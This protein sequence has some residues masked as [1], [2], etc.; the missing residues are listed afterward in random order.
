MPE[1]EQNAL[2]RAWKIQEDAAAVG[3]DWPDISGVLDKIEE[4]VNEMREAL[5]CGDLNHARQ[6]LGDVLLASVNAA[7]FLKINPE[8]MLTQAAN[9]FHARFQAVENVFAQEG[10]DMKSCSLDELDAVWNRVKVAV[11]QALENSA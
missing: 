4:E 10:R 6:E 1:Y 8:V 5:S 11:D 2:Q 3:F 7:R 9:R